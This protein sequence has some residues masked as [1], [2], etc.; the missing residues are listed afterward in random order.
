VQTALAEL[1]ALAT[2][3]VDQTVVAMLSSARDWISLVEG[4]LED[5]RQ[6]F[7]HAA[8]ASPL[9]APSLY[10]LAARAA[11]WLRD[12]VAMRSDLAALDSTTAHGRAVS[13]R[14]TVVEAGIAALE[15]RS[16]EAIA[17]YRTA[18][19]AFDDLGMPWDRALTAIDMATVLDPTDPEVRE[20]AA[21]A[22][23][24]L[25][26]LGARPFLERLE[27]AMATGSREG[28]ELAAEGDPSGSFA[29]RPLTTG[30]MET[31]A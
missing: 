25:A 18:L 7:L 1:D 2:T 4:R 5:A 6:S 20:A 21:A 26:R 23:E 15:G 27:A 13:A 30:T 19:R 3:Q 17:R 10:P 28:P 31:R 14:R 24:I 29:G 11:T 22:R 12:H 9:N 16:G 8:E